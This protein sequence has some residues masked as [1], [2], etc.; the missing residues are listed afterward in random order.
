M[1]ERVAQIGLDVGD[2]F[3]DMSKRY[4]FAY[5]KDTSWQVRTSKT[6]ISLRSLSESLMGVL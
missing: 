1:G 6:Q 3:R 2:N 5:E 4:Q